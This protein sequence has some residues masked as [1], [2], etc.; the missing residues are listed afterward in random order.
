M[1][2]KRNRELD[3]VGSDDNIDGIFVVVGV[4]R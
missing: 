3:V 4:S 2:R 1:R